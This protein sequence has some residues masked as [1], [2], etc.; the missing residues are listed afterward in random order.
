MTGEIEIDV[1][2]PEDPR[3]DHAE[4]VALRRGRLVQL[5]FKRS[6]Q[7]REAAL[8]TIRRTGS[9]KWQAR[10]GGAV[11]GEIVA[12]S[13]RVLVERAVHDHYNEELARWI[14]EQE[15]RW[16]RNDRPA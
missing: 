13:S 1:P 12:K 8:A 9:G 10:I 3:P 7:A 6:R 4:D 2:P 11:R 14:R 15:A 5:R 16:G